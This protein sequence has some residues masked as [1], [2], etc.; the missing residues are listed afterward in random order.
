VSKFFELA[1]E[2]NPDSASS[3]AE[4]PGNT[5]RGRLN[6][7]KS[8]AAERRSPD[9]ILCLDCGGAQPPGSHLCLD[10]GAFLKESNA[11]RRKLRVMPKAPPRPYEP[12]LQYTPQAP[13]A[14]ITP[15]TPG[16]GPGPTTAPAFAP[17]KVSAYAN[18]QHFR[19]KGNEPSP[20]KQTHSYRRHLAAGLAT[21]I[22]VCLIAGGWFGR[23]SFRRYTGR[24][25]GSV[26]SL[27]AALR[28]SANPPPHRSAEPAAGKQKA[29]RWP[30]GNLHE[31]GNDT[32]I[33]SA[34]SAL[35]ASSG[36]PDILEA[37]DLQTHPVEAD[38]SF[39]PTPLSPMRVFVAPRISLAMLIA[40][41][42]PEYP[43][44]A[45][46]EHLEGT[47]TLKA[48]IGKDGNIR[49]LEAVSGP[50]LLV[51]AAIDAVRQWRY[52]PYLVDSQ[53]QEVETFIYKDFH[54][55]DTAS[56]HAGKMANARW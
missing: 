20:A 22:V 54:L 26:E 25:M 35:A 34:E 19:H 7:L 8:A 18:L 46:R 9:D 23:N 40:E 14:S 28:S 12:S 3:S 16:S 41:V 36:Q 47:V 42:D 4:I 50:A 33:V 53:P 38:F 21:L 52:R 51:S 55:A 31:S 29:S 13:A 15:E 10:C 37:P 45:R 43:P 11:A 56:A 32:A 30:H 5:L 44:E 6:A 49:S 2:P 48:V 17:D 27:T 39:V 1:Q 24:I